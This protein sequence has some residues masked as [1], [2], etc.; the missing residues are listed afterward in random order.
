MELSPVGER[1]VPGSTRSRSYWL[2]AVR[3]H[4]WFAPVRRLSGRMLR[5]RESETMWWLRVTLLE[6]ISSKPRTDNRRR[7]S[8]HKAA[9]LDRFTTRGVPATVSHP[10]LPVG[11][12]IN[13]CAVVSTPWHSSGFYCAIDGEVQSHWSRS[14]NRLALDP[15]PRRGGEGRCKL[16]Q[17][18]RR[19]ES[20]YR[21]L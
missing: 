9:M 5:P 14:V 6:S 10:R 17:R 19:G 13:R 15:A 21:S 12:S 8:S 18:I 4:G 3:C 16:S 11:E 20:V 2:A 7:Y 1:Q